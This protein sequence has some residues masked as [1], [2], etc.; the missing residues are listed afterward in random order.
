MIVIIKDSLMFYYKLN[1]KKTRGIFMNMT[2]KNLRKMIIVMVSILTI[3]SFHPLVWVNAESVA[4]WYSQKGLTYQGKNLTA[5]CYITCYAMILK[6]LGIEADPVDVYVANGCSNYANHS[7]IGTAYNVDTSE[8]GSLSGLS[9][10]KKKEKIR[11]LLQSHPEG[12]IVGGC[13]S[14]SS[15]HYV[16]AIKADDNYIYFDDPAYATKA[17]GC[18]I[19][20]G[21]TWKLTWNNLSMYRIVKKNKKPIEQSKEP[22]TTK[23]PQITEKPETNPTSTQTPSPA[24]STA[25]PVV[26][27]KPTPN[28]TNV[29]DYQVP[30]RLIYLKNPI[31]TGED[32]K[33]VQAALHTLGYQ[34]SVDGEFGKDSKKIVKL[35]QGDNKLEAD[36]CV[37]SGTRAAMISSLDKKEI[38]VSLKK[39]SKVSAVNG[40]ILENNTYETTVSWQGQSAAA[41]YQIVYADNEKF[42][43]KKQKKVTKNSIKLT[44]LVPNKT[45][46]IKVRAYGLSGKEKVYGKYSSVMKV[47]TEK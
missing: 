7:K 20:L 37:G 1:L 23:E 12:V 32:V 4:H 21:S 45:Y 42:T 35:Y 10:E 41:G 29:K 24:V 39:V 9:V 34:I 6:N 31:M 28:S 26:T 30:K 15:Y 5:M 14:G 17:D 16:V 13:Y 33:W 36:G 11:Q 43:S 22:E 38:K 19:K 27:P 46:Y 2:K 3:Q 44:K 47:K 25:E 8:K 18:C 40:K